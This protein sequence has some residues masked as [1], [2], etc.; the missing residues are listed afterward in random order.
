M[1][2]TPSPTSYEDT[3]MRSIRFRPEFDHLESLQ[4][5]SGIASVPD[6]TLYGPAPDVA[7][8]VDAETFQYEEDG[9]VGNCTADPGEYYTQQASAGTKQQAIDQLNEARNQVL[10]SLDAQIAV[11]A[12]AITRLNQYQ[13]VIS[14]NILNER[15][16][17]DAT[18]PE[19]KFGDEANRLRDL[20]TDQNN[21]LYYISVGRTAIQA[22]VTSA[23]A[24]KVIT[25]KAYDRAIEIIQQLN[26]SFDDTPAYWYTS[27]PV[28]YMDYA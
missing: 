22:T 12:V 13:G 21:I 5:L 3:A 10:T 19:L 23:N 26:V 17:L 15:A 20:I 27:E 4:L 18:P 16:Q 2:F 14:M 25:N 28:A 9:I 8:L 6:L 24:Q 1:N 11:S 7:P